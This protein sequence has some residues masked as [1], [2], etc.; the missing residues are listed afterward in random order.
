MEVLWQEDDCPAKRIADMLSDRVGWNI[1]TTYTVIKRCIGKGA[2]ER[3]DPGFRCHALIGREAIRAEEARALLDKLFDG[4][5]ELLIA[6]LVS[7]STLSKE[8]IERL[9]AAIDA[10]EE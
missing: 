9:R 8:E 2:I 10:Q 6:S 1:N 7:G 5:A 4:S 3:R